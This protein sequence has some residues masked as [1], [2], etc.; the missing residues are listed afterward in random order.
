MYA[1]SLCWRKC[2]SLCTSCCVSPLCNSCCVPPLC[3][4][5][6][7][8]PLCNCCCA[9]PSCN[10]CYYL[11]VSF[12]NL[13]TCAGAEGNRQLASGRTSVLC[14]VRVLCASVCVCVV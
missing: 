10:S 11:T 4:S 6:F 7:M 13:R 5:C 14:C 12:P 8:P 9:L 2:S 3:N 1:V